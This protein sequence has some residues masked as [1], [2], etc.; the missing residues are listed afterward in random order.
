MTKM[1]NRY[2]D[3]ARKI[4]DLISS[5]QFIARSLLFKPHFV[6]CGISGSGKTFALELA[7]EKL[8]DNEKIAE[9][10]DI[11]FCSDAESAEEVILKDDSRY[12]EAKYIAYSTVRRDVGEN[13]ASKW[14]L[15]VIFVE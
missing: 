11:L 4:L 7:N 14:Y 10:T 9:S 6:I 1:K 13:L 2:E 3:T 5:P 8:P 12:E 15:P